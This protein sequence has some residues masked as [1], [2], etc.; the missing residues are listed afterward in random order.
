M[1]NFRWLLN[2]SVDGVHFSEDQTIPVTYNFRKIGTCRISVQGNQVIG[3]FEL[4]EELTG[5]EYVL[6]TI[7][8]PSLPKDDLW[9][10]GITLTDLY[11]GLEKRAIQA[12][13]MKTP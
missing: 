9:L 6:Y 10:E 4:E 1:K 13:D 5:S 2:W 7:A 12:K 11:D 8:P 3:N